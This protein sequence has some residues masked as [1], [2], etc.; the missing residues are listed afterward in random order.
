MAS[1]H[2]S[3][4]R[5]VGV[6]TKMYFS[7]AHT[8]KYVDQLLQHLSADSSIISE[9]DVFIIPDYISLVSVIHQVQGYKIW[10]GAQDVFYKDSGPYTGEVSPA[11]LAEVGCRLVEVGH[12][13]RRRFFGDTDET[14]AQKAA[15]TAFSGM[16]PLVCIGEQVRGETKAVGQC[17]GQIE[18]VLKALPH[19]AEVAFAYEPI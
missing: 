8:H 3:H 11:V 16:V 14:T 5:I 4:R 15:A 13:E 1:D 10:C 7:V 12:A 19:D 2:R 6:S 9:I 17:R 18:A